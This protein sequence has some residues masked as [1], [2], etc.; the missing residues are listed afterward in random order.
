MRWACGLEFP[1][2][3]DLERQP[4]V[5]ESAGAR[6]VEEVCMSVDVAPLVFMSNIAWLG[7]GERCGSVLPR[8]TAVQAHGDVETNL[9]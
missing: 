3:V 9:D 2:S 4:F 7:V 1:R 6:T 5:E 8:I